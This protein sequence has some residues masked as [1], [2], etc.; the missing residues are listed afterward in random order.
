MLQQH[1]LYIEREVLFIIIIFL[2]LKKMPQHS[3]NQKLALQASSHG[4]EK[5]KKPEAQTMTQQSH[6]NLM[7]EKD[8]CTINFNRI[9]IVFFWN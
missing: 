4:G 6:L 1:V 8:K 2:L 9:Q 3:F 7:K 5:K